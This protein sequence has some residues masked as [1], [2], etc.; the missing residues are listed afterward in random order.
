[1][2][3]AVVVGG[4]PAGS[5]L[6]TR[7]ARAGR[8]VVLFEREAGPADKVCG[9]FLSREA[10]LYLASLGLSLA[11]LGAVPIAALRLCDGGHVATVA[12]PFAAWSLSRRVL[13]EAMLALAAAA[14]ATVRRGVKVTGLEPCPA[15]FQVQLADGMTATWLAVLAPTRVARLCL[16]ATPLRGLSLTRAGLRRDLALLACFLRPLPEVE[17][18]LV[19]RILSRRFRTHHPEEVRRLERALHA[20]PS[21]RTAL[22]EHALAGLR[23]DARRAVG[24]IAAP[25]LVLAGEDDELLGTGP[26]RAL[27][28]AIPGA[29]FETIVASGHDLTLE[30]PIATAARVG[31][32]FAAP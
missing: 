29:V 26:P 13:D 20:E 25:T 6:A 22:L 10:G 23:H 9:E 21:T 18:H 14:G 30:Q 8:E 11:A 2:M 1:M 27:A 24:R 3:Q 15:G 17:A 7:M 4:G 12:L 19:A 32:F 5:A 16:A 28:A 31:R